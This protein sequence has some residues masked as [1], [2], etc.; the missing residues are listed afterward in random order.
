MH[1]GAR[2]SSA[3]LPPNAE[4]RPALL[5]ALL[6]HGGASATLLPPQAY[7]LLADQFGLTQEQRTRLRPGTGD[8][9]WNCR[10]QWARRRGLEQGFI[11]ANNRGAWTLT[12]SGRAAAAKLAEKA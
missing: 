3:D 8:I 10:V 7:A 12:D 2:M 11:I 4:V 9:A 5:L 1:K 6:S